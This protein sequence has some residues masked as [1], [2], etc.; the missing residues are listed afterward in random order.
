MSDDLQLAEARRQQ[1]LIAALVAPEADPSAAPGLLAYRANAHASAVRALGVAC[2]TL[3]ALLGDDDFAQLAREFWHAHP[4]QRGDFAEWGAALP[5]WIAGHTG[6][7]AWPYLA[8]CAWMDLALHRCERAADAAV[9]AASLM[10]LQGSDPARVR[11][12]LMP[13]VAVLASRWPLASIHAAHA[14]G[15]E[16]VFDAVRERMQRGVGEAIVVSRDGW[17]GAVRAI[18]AR[19]LVFMQE[20]ACGASLAQ[21]LAAAGERLDFTAWLADALRYHWLHAVVVTDP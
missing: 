5:E 15:D 18:D 16:A 11:L 21:A 20:L 13:G 8:D 7:A 1:A 2:P 14:A 19:S 4:P 10:L 17:R 6:L 9:E 12:R 3:R